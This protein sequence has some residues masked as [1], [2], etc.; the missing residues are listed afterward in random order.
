MTKYVIAI[1]ILFAALAGFMLYIGNDPELILG[2]TAESGFLKFESLRIPWQ[3]VI[4]LL[5]IATISLIAVW[6]L[7]SWLW[8]LPGRVKSGVGLRRRNRRWMLWKR[9]SLPGPKAM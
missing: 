3:W 8:S 6:S 2:S 1:L 4:G 5:V 9:R 7:L